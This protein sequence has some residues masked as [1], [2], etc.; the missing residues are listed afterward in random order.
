MIE[1]IVKR[2]PP[3]ELRLLLECENCKS[4][5]VADYEDLEYEGIYYS[6]KCP[7]CDHKYAYPTGLGNISKRMFAKTYFKLV[8]EREVEKLKKLSKEGE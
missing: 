5:I 7:V 3:Q 8:S 4:V 6:F 1:I 2:D